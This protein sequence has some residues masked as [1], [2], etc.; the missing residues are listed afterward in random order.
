MATGAGM[1]MVF[2][3][4]YMVMICKA[5]VGVDAGLTVAAVSESCACCSLF[6]LTGDA[7]N[8][9]IGS[10]YDTPYTEGKIPNLGIEPAS[11]FLSLSAFFRVVFLAVG[12]K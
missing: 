7:K 5:A 10:S 6:M 3:C 8:R 2:G 1:D 9:A 4:A 11:P 12:E